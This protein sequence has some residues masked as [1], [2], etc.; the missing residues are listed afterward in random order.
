MRSRPLSGWSLLLVT[1]QLAL[2]SG[3]CSTETKR[4]TSQTVTDAR[5]LASDARSMARLLRDR[6]GHQPVRLDLTNAAQYR[7]VLNRLRASGNTPENSPELFARLERANK[8]RS[9]SPAPG[10]KTVKAAIESDGEWCGHF[11]PIS[12]S[13]GTSSTGFSAKTLAS[14]FNGADYVYAD[15]ALY[16]TTEDG[17]VFEFIRNS[18]AEEY[19]G[20]T[21]FDSGMASHSLTPESG[22]K[23][24]VDSYVLAFNDETGESVSTFL[25]QEAVVATT[26]ESIVLDHPKDRIVSSPDNPI[27]VC[28]ERG[29]VTGNLDCDYASGTMNTGIFTLYTAG[30]GAPTGVAAVDPV[31]STR[32][33]PNRW[34]VSG[35]YWPASPSYDMSHLYLP[36]D[37]TFLPGS[38][39]TG[40]C[41]IISYLHATASIILTEDGGRCQAR[42]IPTGSTVAV[43]GFP[44]VPGPSGRFSTLVDFGATC[45]GQHQNVA[46][47]VDITALADCGKK[48]AS[49]ARVLEQRHSFLLYEPNIDF[50][51]SCLAEGTRILRADGSTLPVEQVQV[52]DRVVANDEGRVLTVTTVSRGGESR[53]LV[54]LRDEAGRE[55]RVTSR[56][57]FLTAEGKVV[58]AE[59]LIRG[60]RVRAKGGVTTLAAV[61]RVPVQG[62]VYN[63][64]LGT[65]AELARIGKQDRTLFANGFLVGDESMQTELDQHKPASGDL[66]ARLSKAWHR[67]YLNKHARKAGTLR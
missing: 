14:C 7:A 2:W 8:R 43:S 26:P 56:H 17:S 55:V 6:P 58:P 51:Y 1:S 62:Q 40:S 42:N 67:D 33:T 19:A 3:G 50:K 37:G 15:V 47:T 60:D 28:L 10:L 35:Y 59:S 29:A 53:P 5:A 16:E 30:G 54:L 38:T 48:D 34:M 11:L 13:S 52:G 45:L 32:V 49:G 4:N 57:P 9:S 27:R 44:M 21:Y 12:K 46:L 22:R 31:E 36:L 66:L 65:E 63:L 41:G 25:G 23:L 18:W 20:G 24:Y 39:Q 61:E 64:A